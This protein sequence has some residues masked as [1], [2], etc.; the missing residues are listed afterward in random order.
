MYRL[1]FCCEI[2]NLINDSIEFPHRLPTWF[3]FY[4]ET[5]SPPACI[6][7][8]YCWRSWNPGV[9]PMSQSL[10]STPT[11][12]GRPQSGPAP[13]PG[14]STATTGTRKETKLPAPASAQTEDTQVRHSTPDPD[15]Q[16]V[17]LVFLWEVLVVQRLSGR[18]GVCLELLCLTCVMLSTLQWG[19]YLWITRRGGKYTKHGNMRW[20]SRSCMNNCCFRWCACCCLVF[21]VSK[22][23]MLHVSITIS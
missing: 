6:L 20:E 14:E 7:F 21:N 9:K 2:I 5:C 10:C 1:H 3:L 23:I 16:N 12:T 4:F 17:P 19:R 11:H 18:V 8:T 22:Y 15:P 13:L